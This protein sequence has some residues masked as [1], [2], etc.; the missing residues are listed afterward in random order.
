MESRVPQYCRYEG[1]RRIIKTRRRIFL[2]SK[3]STGMKGL[4]LLSLSRVVWT[5]AIVTVVGGDAQ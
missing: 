2:G 1:R 4:L 3:S 5:E